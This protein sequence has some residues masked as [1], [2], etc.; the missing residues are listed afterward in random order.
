MWEKST[1]LDCLNIAV[2]S[3]KFLCIINSEVS[4]ENSYSSF[5]LYGTNVLLIK[6]NFDF[7]NFNWKII[8]SMGDK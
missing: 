1:Y 4:W 7:I 5:F 2:L 8:V 6:T 3:V